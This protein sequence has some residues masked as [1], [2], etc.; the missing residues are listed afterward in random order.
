MR[1]VPRSR[2]EPM[3]PAMT[4][5]FLTTASPGKSMNLKKK[6]ISLT[7]Q[8]LAADSGICDLLCGM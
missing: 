5:R 7:H 3:P 4:G 2:I 1:D 8:V 6:C